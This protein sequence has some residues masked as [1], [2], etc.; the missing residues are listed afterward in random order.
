MAST[1]AATKVLG[2]T[3]EL[4]PFSTKKSPGRRK[5]SLYMQKLGAGMAN[6]LF[7]GGTNSEVNERKNLPPGS[8]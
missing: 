3:E 2:S 1:N 5:S 8:M 4:S 6:V 7:H